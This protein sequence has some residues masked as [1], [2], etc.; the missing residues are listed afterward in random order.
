MDDRFKRGR[1]IQRFTRDPIEF[2]DAIRLACEIAERRYD[3]ER[4]SP[5]SLADR[6]VQACHQGREALVRRALSEGAD[7]NSVRV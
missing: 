7:P 4:K 2:D 6:L 1:A 3:E 5:A